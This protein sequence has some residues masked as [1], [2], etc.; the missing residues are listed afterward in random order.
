MRKFAAL[1][2]LAITMAMSP[3][4]ADAPVQTHYSAASTPIGTL[5]ANPAA[6]ASIG[7]RFPMLL[8]SKAVT[9]GMANRMTLRSLKR[10]KPAIFTDAAL[11]AI[12]ADFA[13]MPGR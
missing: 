2:A 6:R 8:Q 3:A 4:I 12:D 7:R 9:S 1:A 13:H 10:F 11:A 5:L